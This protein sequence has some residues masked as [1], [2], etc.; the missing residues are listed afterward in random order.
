MADLNYNIPT[1]PQPHPTDKKFEDIT[2]RTFNQWTVLY[3]GGVFNK[4]GRWVVQCKCGTIKLHLANNL[5][6]EKTKSCGCIRIENSQYN[7]KCLHGNCSN[8]AKTKNYCQ[9]HY[10]RLRS[11]GDVNIKLNTNGERIPWLKSIVDNPPEGCAIPPFPSNKRGYLKVRFKGEDN[12]GHR[13][14]LILFTG[15]DHPEMDAAHGP[16][17]NRLCCNPLHLSWKTRLENNND[18]KRDGTWGIKLTK[19]KVIAIKN[20]YPRLTQ[21]E[22]ASIYNIDR[23]TVGNIMQGKIWKHL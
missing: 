14:A 6:R 15:K 2:G 23:S 20:L 10:T 22:I 8:K 18:K 17:H 12:L 21:E 4:K 7:K 1:T 16:C 13:V 19:E 5:I 9:K 11:H 3:F